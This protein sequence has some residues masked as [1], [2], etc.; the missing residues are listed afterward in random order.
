MFVAALP[1]YKDTKIKEQGEEAPWLGA[2]PVEDCCK[3]PS[4]LFSLSTDCAV[5]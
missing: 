4:S 5:H 1:P 2:P 3:H